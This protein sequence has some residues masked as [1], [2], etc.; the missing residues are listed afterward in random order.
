M[1]NRSKLADRQAREALD[2]QLFIQRYGRKA[3]GNGTD[4]NDRSYD[5]G[6]KAKLK[7]MTPERL[8]ALLRDGDDP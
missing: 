4:P 8:D 1:S 5:R 3:R 2:A 7:R 6:M